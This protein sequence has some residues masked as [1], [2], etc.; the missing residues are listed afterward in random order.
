MLTILSSEFLFQKCVKDLTG[1][2]HLKML[3]L[4]IGDSTD[5]RP[6]RNYRGTVCNESWKSVYCP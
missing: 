4:I 1:S 2:L 5:L 3:F 6:E